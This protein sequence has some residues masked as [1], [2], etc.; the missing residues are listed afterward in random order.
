MRAPGLCAETDLIDSSELKMEDRGLL[1]RLC[2]YFQSKVLRLGLFV[3]LAV[4][5][6]NRLNCSSSR[7]FWL[8]GT[9]WV[10]REDKLNKAQPLCGC[11]LNRSSAHA[12]AAMLTLLEPQPRFGDKPV[13]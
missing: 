13:K 1:F 9:D 7:F 10:G 11:A 5:A 2:F 6:L 8:C 3:Q 12:Q 4:P